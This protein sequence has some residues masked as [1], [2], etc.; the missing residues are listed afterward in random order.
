[1]SD[2]VGLIDT[3]NNDIH[4]EIL[5]AIGSYNR[6]D[7]FKLTA[8]V[9]PQVKKIADI[10]GGTTKEAKTLYVKTHTYDEF[11]NQIKTDSLFV[12]K[13]ETLGV[14]SEQD[15]K[16]GELTPRSLWA[17]G[18]LDPIDFTLNTLINRFWGND[19]VEGI[20]A[21]VTKFL[22]KPKFKVVDI[23]GQDVIITE[24]E[25]KDVN[26]WKTVYWSRATKAWHN[27]MAVEPV[28]DTK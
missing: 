26:K 3:S 16:P 21:V 5:Y 15:W 24:K 11:Y 14:P 17:K 1:L 6:D 12:L 27:W 23:L 22:D 4:A 10:V 28:K 13:K 8:E 19:N 25:F 2:Y 20:S 7:L 18:S 9:C